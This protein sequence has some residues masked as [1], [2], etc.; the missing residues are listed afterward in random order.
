MSPTSFVAPT[1]FGDFGGAFAPET[2]MAPLLEL[3][4]AWL[5][6]R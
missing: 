1:R 6:S 5:A 4:R 3:E 2:L